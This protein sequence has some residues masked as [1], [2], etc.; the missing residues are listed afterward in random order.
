MRKWRTALAAISFGLALAGSLVAYRLTGSAQGNTGDV[1]V[2]TVGQP[3]GPGAGSLAPT[4][5]P[6]GTPGPSPGTTVP[7]ATLAGTG[8]GPGNVAGSEGTTAPVAMIL[9]LAGGLLLARDAFRR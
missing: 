3:S 7:P 4:A 1:W 5:A 2:D 6:T 8:G 9:I